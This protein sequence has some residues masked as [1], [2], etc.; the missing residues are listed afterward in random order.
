MDQGGPVYV[1][2]KRLQTHFH[3]MG[4]PDSGKSR[5]LLSV[6]ECLAPDPN[7][8]IVGINP[9][10]AL[11][12][13]AR[14]WIIGHGLAKRLVWFDPGEAGSV[15]GYNPLWPNGLAPTT[16]AKAVRE[17]IRSAWG[18]SS[19]D[20]TPQ[21]A[22]LLYLSLAVAR[23]LGQTLLEALQL[24]RSG[25]AGSAFRAALFPALHDR[26]LTDALTWFDS[27]HERRQEEI[28]ASTVARLESFICDP[29]IC[30]ILTQPHPLNLAHVFAERKILLVNL[31]IGRPLL[32]DDVKL[33]GRFIVNDVV[34]HL[35]SRPPSPNAP[36]YLILDEVQNFATRD[37]CSVLDMGR[38]LGLHCIL[39]H[40]TLGQLR[41][42]DDTQFLYDS[43]MGCARTKFYF[44]GLHVQD[45]E[46]LVKD[47]CIGEFN[48]YKVK[49]ELQTLILDPTE[50]RRDVVTHGRNL[51]ASRSVARGESY[52]RSRTRSTAVAFGEGESF[53]DG[54]SA[55]AA[56]SFGHV[57]G[58]QSGFGA[59][60]TILPTGEIVES[61]HDM[62]GTS[63]ADITTST[64]LHG[65]SHAHST[66]RTY[67]EQ[68]GYAE[69]EG[70]ATQTARNAGVNAGVS[71]SRSRVPFYE[72]KKLWRVSSRTFETEQEFLTTRLQK[73]KGLPKA[74]CFVKVPGKPGCFVALPWIR[75]PSISS[76][77]RAAGMDRVFSQTFY[78][79]PDAATPAAW[80]P[81]LPQTVAP[82][83]SNAGGGAVK[84]EEEESYAGPVITP[85][86]LKRKTRI[87]KRPS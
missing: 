1:R 57:S 80:P 33:L 11:T 67:A 52:A 48:P 24:L 85:R 16:H 77:T 54:V 27:L 66:H 58:S 63:S 53:T 10:G 46:L 36:V 59:G 8:T 40:Q 29:L 70:E 68:Y 61:F 3:V 49:D 38:E 22:R 30:R 13:M 87:K 73:I 39:A 81:A 26:F 83:P 78:F 64:D 12:R 43:V 20:Q 14:D 56:S 37:L 15:I 72:Y 65:E 62:A 31:E 34:N 50:S 74:H 19:F 79:R 2:R 45:L 9:K 84:S 69:G 71:D 28:A 76:K 4:P 60:E 5:F 6:L 23:T 86:P 44:G 42:E 41:G 21:M 51:G 7:A 55:A 25:P 35:F 18:Q 17:A 47:A 82:I 75:T 32:M